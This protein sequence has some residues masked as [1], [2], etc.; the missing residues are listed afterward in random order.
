MKSLNW[1]LTKF[2]FVWNLIRYIYLPYESSLKQ[3]IASKNKSVP[4]FVAYYM[5]S[6]LLYTKSFDNYNT[7]VFIGKKNA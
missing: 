6:V 1:D 3:R 5:N 4:F 7:N 2:N